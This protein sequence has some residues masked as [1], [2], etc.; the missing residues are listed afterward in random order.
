MNNEIPFN[1][2]QQRQDNPEDRSL[3]SHCQ[4]MIWSV[5]IVTLFSIEAVIRSCHDAG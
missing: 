1:L 3:I 2:L 4:F 5:T